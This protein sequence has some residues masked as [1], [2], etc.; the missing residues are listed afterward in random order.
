MALATANCEL[1]SRSGGNDASV[2][3]PDMRLDDP[4]HSGIRR[5][6]KEYRHSV[7]GTMT[8][9]VWDPYCRS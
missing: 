8:R 9:C 1:T 3:L 4:S 5:H 7:R 6:F 2:I